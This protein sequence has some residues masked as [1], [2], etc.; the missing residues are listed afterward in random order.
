MLSSIGDIF[1]SDGVSFAYEMLLAL[2][3][4]SKRT[5]DSFPGTHLYN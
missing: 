4:T 2:M 5:T 1:P 3:G